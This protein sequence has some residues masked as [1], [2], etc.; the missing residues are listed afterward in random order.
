[1]KAE[2]KK[3]IASKLGIAI[4]KVQDDTKIVEDLGYDS[5]DTV[6]MLMNL[7]EEFNISIPDE[8]AMEFKTLGNVADYLDTV[9]K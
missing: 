6:E 9:N 7:E 5:L 1:M 4:D 3:I 8:K 2:M